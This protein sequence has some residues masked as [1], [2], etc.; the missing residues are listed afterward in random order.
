MT[1]ENTGYM[2]SDNSHALLYNHNNPDHGRT[3]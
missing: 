1:N 2:V 3:V